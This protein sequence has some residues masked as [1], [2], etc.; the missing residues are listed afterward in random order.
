MPWLSPKQTRMCQL[1]PRGDLPGS[2]GRLL[3]KQLNW[4]F[5]GN[6]QEMGSRWLFRGLVVWCCWYAEWGQPS[7]CEFLYSWNLTM[8]CFGRGS[9]E[10]LMESKIGPKRNRESGAEMAPPC[11]GEESAGSA[12]PGSVPQWLGPV[13]IC[14][15]ASQSWKWLLT[16]FV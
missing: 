16:A 3:K 6:P 15:W 9:G 7:I 11:L 8:H 12:T 13:W 4:S 14:G 10:I 1:L 5:L 2:E